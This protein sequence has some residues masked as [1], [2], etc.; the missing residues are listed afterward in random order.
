MIARSPILPPGARVGVFA[1]SGRFDPTRRDAGLAWL[2][3]H[4]WV[5]V[6]LDLGLTADRYLAAPDADRLARLQRAL[7]EPGV[8]ALWAVRGGYG[9]TP[10]L[11]H[12]RWTGVAPLPI[13]GFS[14]VTPL[15]DLA[16]RQTG[17]RCVHG[18]VLHS[19]AGTAPRWRDH[20]VD[21]LTDLPLA[22]LHGTPL[23]DGACEGPLRGGNL[24]LLAATCGTPFQL[25]AAG[26]I[27]VLEDVGEPPY[28]LDRML[29]QLDQ[30]GVF[31]GVVGVALG[32]F[33]GGPDLP[34]VPEVLRQRLAGLGVP[35]LMDLPIGH[36]E[37]NAAWEVG[38]VARVD[39][40][41]LS[42][43]DRG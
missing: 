42:W 34:G 21:V 1:P 5:P 23:V 27:L 8:D 40:A 43:P 2:T 31:R 39:G 10:L 24:A 4:G 25:D 26:A 3:D 33:S 6:R 37:A 28:R 13:V 30:A 38:R 12:L 7:R 11:P 36:T 32:T 14:D 18:P 22:P 15:L 9:L 29:V 17:A 41:T 20:L 16:Q 35:V 19:L